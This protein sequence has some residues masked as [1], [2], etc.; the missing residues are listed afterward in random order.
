M[1]KRPSTD[2]LLQFEWVA[3]ARACSTAAAEEMDGLVETLVVTSRQL[4]DEQ[5]GRLV[6]KKRELSDELREL[7]ETVLREVEGAP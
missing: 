4:S 7:E 1:S 3:A 5:R 6:V 2:E